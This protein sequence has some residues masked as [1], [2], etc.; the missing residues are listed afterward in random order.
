MRPYRILIFSLN[1]IPVKNDSLVEGTGLRCWRLAQG[2]S[3]NK[4]VEVTVGVHNNEY[5]KPEI[6][7]RFNIA[8]WGKSDTYDK[9]LISSFDAVLIPLSMSGYSDKI[10]NLLQRKQ[11]LIVDSYSNFYV[12]SLTRS[13]SHK[14][15]KQIDSWYEGM[16]RAGNYSIS[17]ADHILY[18]NKNQK[19][20]YT[21]LLAGLGCLSP[22]I[23]TNKLFIKVPGAVEKELNYSIKYKKPKN[24]KLNILW[25][26]AIYPWYNIEELIDIF[27]DSHISSIASLNIVGGYNKM[28][29]K[30]NLRFNGQY[31]SALNKARKDGT[32]N[33]GVNFYEW[34]NYYERLNFFKQNDI[35][36]SMNSKS[37]ENEYSWRIR[38][39]DLAGNGIPIITNGGDPLDDYLIRNN[40][41]IY[42][43]NKSEDIKKIIIELYN[44]KKL[45]INMRLSLEKLYEEL[46]I[47]KYTN[48]LVEILKD[49][50]YV[51][52]KKSFIIE[53]LI[54]CENSKIKLDEYL[55]ENNK[56]LNENSLLRNDLDKTTSNYKKINESL[57]WR[58]TKPLRQ[59]SSRV[60]SKL[61]KVSKNE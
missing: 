8:K 16:V 11:R 15:D 17:K 12:E 58:L 3:S 5:E 49:K 43:L 45:L 38:V 37:L 34:T 24:K 47:Y 48:K 31:Y 18:A 28:Y 55:E 2:L 32:L 41:A 9:K 23:D 53:D 14:D 35:A 44:N 51:K 13:G 7:L 52:S 30:N 25:F 36:I 19:N 27:K 22:S 46:H 6:S 20:F 10:I 42:S 60:K 50:D 40:A 56:L 57:S 33:N 61:R 39:A 1:K 26:G 29:P 59:V 21:G 4:N 54:K